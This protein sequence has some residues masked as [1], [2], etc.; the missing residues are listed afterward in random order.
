MAG[1]GLLRAG[2]GEPAWGDGGRPPGE[3]GALCCPGW[4]AISAIENR[5]AVM[6]QGLF[7]PNPQPAGVAVQEGSGVSPLE[8][9]ASL[10]LLKM[11]R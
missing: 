1:R 7:Y 11:K 8:P 9:A 4:S 6:Q 2:T 5:R 3:G 10:G